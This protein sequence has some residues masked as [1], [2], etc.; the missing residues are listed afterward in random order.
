VEMESCKPQGEANSVTAAHRFMRSGTTSILGLSLIWLL[1]IG[2]GS[3]AQESPPTEYEYQLKAAFLLNFAKFVEWPPAPVAKTNFVLGILG[4]NPFGD[5][6]QNMIKGKTINNH[7]LEVTYFD[8]SVVPTNCHLLFISKSEKDRLPEI[9][10]GLDNASVLTVGETEGFT[11]EGMIGFVKLE[12]VNKIRFQI[13]E[14]AA[15][16]AHLKISSKLLSLASHTK[17]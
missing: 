3:R 13:N 1:L 12:G 9:I 7:P 14:Q 16:D 11:S 6:L 4:K 17:Q 15:R 5:T 10:K 8:S 2:G